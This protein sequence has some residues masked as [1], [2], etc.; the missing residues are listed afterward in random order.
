MEDQVNLGEILSEILKPPH[1]TQIR[2][3]LALSLN[4]KEQLQ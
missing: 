1:F 2:F 3:K 4:R